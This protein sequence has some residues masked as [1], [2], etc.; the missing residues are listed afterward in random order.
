MTN[1]LLKTKE[2]YS[3]LNNTEQKIAT[4]ILGNP[5]GILSMPIA[6]LAINSGVSQAA[7]V[8]FCKTM[9]FQGLKELKKEMIQE[10]N[11]GKTENVSEDTFNDIRIPDGI[12][13]IHDRVRFNNITSI[14]DTMKVIDLN[15]ADAAAKAIC[16]AKRVDFYGVGASGIVALDAQS[17]F[18]RIGKFSLSA[19]DTHQQLVNAATL[20]QNDVAVMIS[21]S[22]TTKE[23]IEVLRT[24]KESKATVISITKYGKNQISQEADI[25]LFI[26]ASEI[27]KRSGAMG[28]R[29][30]QLTVIDLLFTCVANSSYKEIESILNR[31]HKS[32][33]VRHS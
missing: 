1:F 28:S 7:W 11:S 32:T 21:Y 17:K 27:E 22:G 19:Q 18:L 33:S 10:L 24:A 12:Q 6:E 31:T 4:Y 16:K 26:S 29:I 23:M 25:P 30:A 3:D 5:E 9:G 14:E 8:R 2:I 15:Q 13:S 20:T